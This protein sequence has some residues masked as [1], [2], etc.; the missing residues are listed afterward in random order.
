MVETGRLIMQ[1]SRIIASGS[2]RA[3]CAIACVTYKLADGVAKLRDVVG[4]IGEV[5]RAGRSDPAM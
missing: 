4:E 1:R 5:A 2:R 3:T